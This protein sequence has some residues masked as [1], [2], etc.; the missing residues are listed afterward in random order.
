MILRTNHAK[1]AAAHKA[2]TP[3]GTA[4]NCLLLK[5]TVRMAMPKNAPKLAFLLM[6][7][8]SAALSCGSRSEI[9]PAR[10]VTPGSVPAIVRRPARC[11]ELGPPPDYPPASDAFHIGY[12]S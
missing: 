3:H 12:T 9:A 7:N 2:G 10:C 8:V 11:R 5:A 1:A 6:K 4:T